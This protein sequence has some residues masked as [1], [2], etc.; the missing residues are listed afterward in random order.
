[1]GKGLPHL[2]SGK[3]DVAK[4]LDSPNVSAENLQ[5][6][7]VEF[8][9]AAGKNKE[10]AGAAIELGVAAIFVIG[11]LVNA[12]FN[13]SS[14]VKITIGSATRSFHAVT[15]EC[16]RLIQNLEQPKEQ[17]AFIALHKA[18]E[19]AYIKYLSLEKIYSTAESEF[20]VLLTA[21]KEAA[22]KVFAV[23]EQFKNSKPIYTAAINKIKLK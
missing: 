11:R 6:F 12:H 10:S 14:K 19:K 18:M 9:I 1:M 2:N 23:W 15:D 8:E 4:I 5:V 7:R 20:G 3:L 16:G 22:A 21:A 13:Q 17:K